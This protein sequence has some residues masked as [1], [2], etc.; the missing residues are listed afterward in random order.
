MRFKCVSKKW[1][2]IISN[3]SPLFVYLQ[4][5][6]AAS[7][8]LASWFSISG[9][10]SRAAG[11]LSIDRRSLGIPSFANQIKRIMGNS[12]S[13]LRIVASCNGLLCCI[14]DDFPDKIVIGNPSLKNW[15]LLPVN[16][17]LNLFEGR[18]VVYGLAVDVEESSV[19]YRLL[20]LI[21]MDNNEYELHVFSSTTQQWTEAVERIMLPVG[22]Y[23]DMD[24]VAVYAEDYMYWKL[25]DDCRVFWFS[26]G[27]KIYGLH[28]LPQS[29]DDPKRGCIGQYGG[30]LSYAMIK[31]RGIEMWSLD[32]QHQHWSRSFSITLD[33]VATSCHSMKLRKT[34]HKDV[35]MM[36]FEGG[37]L[38]SFN[39]DGV[40][41]SY[42]ILAGIVQELTR[43][44]PSYYW[45][46]YKNTLV[47][48]SLEEENEERCKRMKKKM[49]NKSMKQIRSGV[50]HANRLMNFS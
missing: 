17:S 26:I 9:C 29:V 42:D 43:A 38:L 32:H 6:H 13:C 49:E 11:C 18:D 8:L 2:H 1:H 47:P 25:E 27:T 14:E 10:L 4:S 23:I 15:K 19:R 31:G 36:P 35:S 46:P 5:Q 3:P 12:L 50:P 16:P 34:R 45:F 24:Q 48:L 20:L 21:Y 41:Y 22:A 28:P 39:V 40:I 30:K 37:D 7:C 33:I 44:H